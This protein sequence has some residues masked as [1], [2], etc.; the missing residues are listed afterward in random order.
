VSIEDEA[1]EAW[2]A[3][4]LDHQR[5]NVR[6][7]AYAKTQTDEVNRLWKEVERLQAEIKRCPIDHSTILGRD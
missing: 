3:A 5:D 6:L 1:Y 2:R 7:R 4:A